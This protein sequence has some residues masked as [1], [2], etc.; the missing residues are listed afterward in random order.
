MVNS[1]AALKSGEKIPP[2]LQ[3]LERQYVV[4]IFL[5]CTK[6]LTNK[7]FLVRYTWHANPRF[8]ALRG[9]SRARV[10]AVLAPKF[11]CYVPATRPWFGAIPD[12]NVLYPYTLVNK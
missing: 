7:T 8:G 2:T 10:G 1:S 9:I 5:N 12:R 3:I 11:P 6:L 4:E